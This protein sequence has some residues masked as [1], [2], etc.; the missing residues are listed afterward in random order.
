MAS[1]SVHLVDVLIIGGGPAG[2][3]AANALVRQL[4]TAIVFNSSEFRNAR[5]AHMHN[6]AGFDHTPPSEFRAKARKDIL[7]R[8]DT[9]EF[10]DVEIKTITKTEEGRFEATDA[11]GAKYVGKKVV[12][13]TGVRDI[14]PDIPGAEERWGRG[15]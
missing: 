11:S 6:V 13:G 10:R 5:A 2:L 9:V 8:Y 4:H 3:A 12:L 1:A 7:A 14:I 15:L